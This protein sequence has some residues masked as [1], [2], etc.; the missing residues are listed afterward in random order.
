[1]AH[2]PMEEVDLRPALSEQGAEHGCMVEISTGR[3]FYRS[4]IHKLLA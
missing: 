4:E 3:N 2:V 1:M